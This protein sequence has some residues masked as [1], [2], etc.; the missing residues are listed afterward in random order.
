MKSMTNCPLYFLFFCLPRPPLSS[1]PVLY[2]TKKNHNIHC[3][4]KN[5]NKKNNKESFLVDFLLNSLK[6]VFQ[7]RSDFFL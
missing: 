2:I 1:G 7:K 6:H 5:N 3:E 4:N